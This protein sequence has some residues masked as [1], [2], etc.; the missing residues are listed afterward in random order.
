MTLSRGKSLIRLGFYSIILGE[1]CAWASDRPLRSPLSEIS[2]GLA[3]LLVGLGVLL[4]LVG[5][6]VLC[7][8][9]FPWPLLRAGT[10]ASTVALLVVP[11]VTS[12]A[13]F[14]P[15]VHSWTGLLFF[16]WLFFCLLSLTILLVGLV[17]CLLQRRDV[18]T[19]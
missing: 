6:I 19:V 17:R 14:E 10:I 18:P 7:I 12:M 16:L 1:L 11:A 2:E 9:E 4:I 3:L 5:C 15:N 13:H 8:K